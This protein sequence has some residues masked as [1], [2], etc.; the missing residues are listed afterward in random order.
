MVRRCGKSVF[1]FEELRLGRKQILTLNSK[2]S[3]AGYLSRS[4]LGQLVMMTGCPPVLGRAK[5]Q[6]VLATEIESTC[7]AQ[8]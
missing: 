5:L 3:V 7:A 4:T 2:A 6:A 8:Q 1:D